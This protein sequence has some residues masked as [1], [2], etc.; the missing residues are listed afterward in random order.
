M[1]KGRIIDPLRMIHRERERKKVKRVD[2]RDYFLFRLDDLGDDIY[3][4]GVVLL[5][6]FQ[7]IADLNK[8]KQKKNN[9]FSCQSS[10]GQ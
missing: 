8:S 3:D 9:K 1:M 2:R 5:S 6:T 4:P 7:I 10:K